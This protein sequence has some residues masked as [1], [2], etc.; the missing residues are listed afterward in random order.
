MPRTPDSI[1]YVLRLGNPTFVTNQG[2][3]VTRTIT[4]W[5]GVGHQAV[6]G[7]VT[8]YNY[9]PGDLQ[10][11]FQGC[12]LGISVSVTYDPSTATDDT[13]MAQLVAAVKAQEDLDDT[14]VIVLV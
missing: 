4:V 7:D 6:S 10:S 8:P 13:V 3:P 14:D 11:R 2:P 9:H 12:A 1:N 5:Y